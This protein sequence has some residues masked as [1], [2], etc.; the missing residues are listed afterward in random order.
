MSENAYEKIEPVK[1][2]K[3]I[4][5]INKAWVGSSFEPSKTVVHARRLSFL[6]NWT[7]VEAEDGVSIPEKKAV[8][9]DDGQNTVPMQYDTDFIVNFLKKQNVILNQKQAQDYLH[10]WFEYVRSGAERFLLIEGIDD[11][12]WREEVS[13]QVRKSLARTIIPVTF[14]NETLQGFVFKVTVLFRDTLVECL[15]EIDFTGDVRLQ[16]QSIIVE[17]LTVIDV[18]TGF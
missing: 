5:R 1:A 4:E 14:L 6:K 10:F 2:K 18:L 7:L 16:K 12:P 3:I 15:A 11:I 13:P 17:N 9:L 8:V